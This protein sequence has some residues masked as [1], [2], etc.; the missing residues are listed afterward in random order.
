MVEKKFQKRVTDFIITHAHADRIGGIKT[1]KERGIKAHSTALTAELAK[2]NGYEEPLGDLQTITS[3]KFGNTK[4]ETFHPGKGRTEDNIVVWLPQYKILAGGCLVK[5]AEAKDLGNV[6]DAYVNEWSTSIEN[7]LKR[8]GN[9]NSVV[10]GHGEVGDRG[11]LL[12]TLDL[13]K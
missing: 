8:Y 12:H 9:I 10:P 3:L 7:V 1:L 6:A 4:V 11:L 2:K 13:L 5:S